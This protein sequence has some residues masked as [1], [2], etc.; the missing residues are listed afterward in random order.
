MNFCYLVFMIDSNF[1]LHAKIYKVSD[2]TA[3]TKASSL[4]IEWCSR[5][6]ESQGLNCM[7]KATHELPEQVATEL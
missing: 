5:V 4:Q 6:D 2:E 1:Q 3:I 7:G